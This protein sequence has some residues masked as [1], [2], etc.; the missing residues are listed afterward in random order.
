MNRLAAL[1]IAVLAACGRS[2]VDD[3][4]ARR[5]AQAVDEIERVE[6]R[7]RQ[8]ISELS[9]AAGTLRSAIMRLTDDWARVSAEL[10][11]VTAT[12]ERARMIGEQAGAE[13]KATR[14]Q[15]AQAAREYRIVT[16]IIIIAAASDVL[17]DALCQGKMSTRT[18]RNHLRAEG[19]S[20]DGFDVDHV[21]PRA[22]GGADHPWNYQLLDSSLNR[23]LGAGVMEKIVS[24]PLATLQGL[25]ASALVS[26]RCG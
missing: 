20:V 26:L 14:E 5:A 16:A 3:E 18:F 25:V 17:G 7:D 10:R 13:L 4:P 21:L 23:S 6:A 9:A 15:Y 2:S 24:E 22:L 12:Y 11:T 8:T 1:A 19:I